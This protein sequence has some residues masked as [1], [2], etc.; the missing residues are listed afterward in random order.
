MFTRFSFRIITTQFS[1][2]KN[3]WRAVIYWGARCHES[4]DCV[5]Y[6]QKVCTSWFSFDGVFWW[7]LVIN[8]ATAFCPIKNCNRILECWVVNRFEVLWFWSCLLLYKQVRSL[9]NQA[10]V[11]F[12]FLPFTHE[13]FNCCYNWLLTSFISLNW[14]FNHFVKKTRKQVKIRF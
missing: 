8:F 10:N 4:A 7:K 14:R 13:L 6:F 5:T 1:K 3:S 11:E 2:K 12:S 9:S